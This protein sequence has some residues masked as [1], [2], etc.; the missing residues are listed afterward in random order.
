MK[1]A[2]FLIALGASAQ[3]LTVLPPSVEL[4][5]RE[6]RQQLIAESS[7]NG[8]QQDWTRQVTWTTSNPAVAKVDGSGLVLPAGDGE[9]VITAERNGHKATA[10][11]RVSNNKA[12]F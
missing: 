4:N 11:I 6:S 8:Y 7:A 9:A 2:S 3:T 5:S 12:P 10:R 1:F